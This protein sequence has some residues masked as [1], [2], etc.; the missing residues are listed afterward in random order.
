MKPLRFSCTGRSWRS[1][2]CRRMVGRFIVG[3]LAWGRG[4]WRMYGG[5]ENRKEKRE[6]TKWGILY[7]NLWLPCS[8]THAQDLRVR[9]VKQWLLRQIL[10]AP[11]RSVLTVSH[12]P[13]SIQLPNF[14]HCPVGSL[15]HPAT[16]PHSKRNYPNVFKPIDAQSLKYQYQ[17][18]FITSLS[19][20]VPHFSNISIATT[21]PPVPIPISYPHSILFPHKLIYIPIHN[22]DGILSINNFRRDME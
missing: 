13:D 3:S 7:L 14:Y 2:G 19:L 15:N 22:L 20:S 6:E 8:T 12:S 1:G 11:Y 5:E 9:L 21:V 10:T 18:T 16:G 4:W 17:Q